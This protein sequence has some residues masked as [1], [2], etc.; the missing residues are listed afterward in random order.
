[1]AKKQIFLLHFAGGNR[2]SFRFLTEHISNTLEC[3]CLELPG[4]G[5]RLSEELIRDFRGALVDF[6]NQVKNLR[7]G[8]DYVVYGHSMGALAALY[9]TEHM[10]QL[11]DAPKRLIVTGSSG[12]KV[13]LNTKRY[14]LNDEDFK[15]ELRGLGGI[16]EEALEHQEIFHFFAPILRADFEILEFQ[17]LPNVQIKSDV[18]AIMGDKEKYAKHICEWNTLSSGNVDTSLLEGDHFFILNHPQTLVKELNKLV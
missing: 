12:P 14:E 17:K 18:I 1:M 11:N 4:R 7:N 3:H 13:G 2:Y 8:E 10:E 9:L 16:P 15:E 5:K 6:Q